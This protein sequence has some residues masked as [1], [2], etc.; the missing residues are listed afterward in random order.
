MSLAAIFGSA[1]AIGSIGNFINAADNASAVRSANRQQL[2]QTRE[3]VAFQEAIRQRQQ[4]IAQQEIA[5]QQ[6]MARVAGDA[7]GGSLGQFQGD[8][9]Q[10]IG[11]ASSQIADFYRE[12]LQRKTA[13]EQATTALM[14][15]ATGPTADRQASA[16]TEASA[17]VQ[18]D[19][20]RMADV[21]GFGE[22]MRQ[23]SE[24]MG[25]NEQLAALVNNFAR[26]SAGAGQA[27]IGAQAGRFMTRDIQPQPNGMLGDLFVGLSGLAN[28]YMQNRPT[29]STVNYSL[30]TGTGGPS[31]RIGG[32]ESLRLGGGT[33][34]VNRS[35]L[36]I[37]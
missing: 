2:A 10:R 16:M 24:A 17:N 31:L 11:G 19:A 21:Q 26:G 23:V 13:Q 9:N 27:E 34:L 32:G 12:F 29:P 15:Q 33:G 37:R 7:F 36:G 25:G 3:Q 30:S 1:P 6:I 14:P 28:Q 5:R 22:A 4:E 35:N 8:F 20:G 18:G